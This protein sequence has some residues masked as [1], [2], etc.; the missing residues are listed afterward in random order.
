MGWSRVS[1]LEW[2]ITVL[3]WEI[4]SF[5]LS[6][7]VPER[8]HNRAFDQILRVFDGLK[9]ALASLF[10]KAW[11]LVA[12]DPARIMHSI[13]VGI[14]LVLVS[15]FYFMNPLFESSG[16]MATWA[17]MTVVVIFEFTAGA[18]LSKGLNRM[19][20]TFLGGLLAVA[21]TYTARL[22]PY[23]AQPFIIGVA[24]FLLSTLSTFARLSPKIKAGYDYGFMIFI[25]TFS[26]IAIA[27]Y[28]DHNLFEYAYRRMETILMG[29]GIC[30]L[31]SLLICPMWAGEELHK[32]IICN[33]EGLAESLDGCVTEYFKESSHED[34]DNDAD[35]SK[36]YKCV[37]N[38]KAREEALANFARWEFPVH[39]QFRFRYPWME[40]V[41][42]GARM[43]YCAY[44]VEALNGCLKSEIQAP[45]FLREHLKA[46]C[47]NIVAES[48]KVILA[49]ADSIKTM[50]RC[51]SID[52]MT[53][54]LN[55][56][57]EELQSCLTSQPEL[58]IDSK[59]WEVLEETSQQKIINLKATRPSESKNPQVLKVKDAIGR[60]GEEMKKPIISSSDKIWPHGETPATTDDYAVEGINKV[61]KYE[62][63]Q[64]VAF[65]DILP[66]ATVACLLTEI[67]AR[68]A[69]LIMA[70]DELGERANFTTIV[71]DKP[72]VDK[73]DAPPEIPPTNQSPPLL[74]PIQSPPVVI[75][76]ADQPPL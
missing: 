10:K 70:V 74:P 22:A 76:G 17:I 54:G 1:N 34:C 8:F 60:A 62:T 20:A 19:F 64:G 6:P 55:R 23:R 75:P 35:V 5:E 21:V 50:T 43:R 57:A 16:G 46:P 72:I 31:I 14:A 2:E 48:S 4:G 25:L 65:M 26:F 49:L 3:E 61:K 30:I 7:A 52:L 47:M 56:A 53:D 71:D 67:V 27:G 32:L 40:Y 45:Y 29:C 18:T 66:L 44:S 36:G 63:I 58:F 15:L 68:L 41:K 39:G 37:L 33:L 51:T 42:I 13:K 59:M 12:D 69:T 73:N 9:S 38:S 24:V 28:R 11:R